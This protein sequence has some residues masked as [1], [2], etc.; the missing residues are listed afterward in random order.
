MDEV[1]VLDNPPLPDEFIV[2]ELILPV[3]SDILITAFEPLF[4]EFETLVFV[5]DKIPL[6]PLT[7]SKETIVPT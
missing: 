2:K 3:M 4:D 1:F 5:L 7:I 6:P